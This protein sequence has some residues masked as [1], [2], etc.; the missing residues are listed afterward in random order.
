MTAPQAS[1]FRP[2]ER[3]RVS[4]RAHAG[5]HRT[6]RYIQGKVGQVQVDN[7]LW[8]NPETRAYGGSGLPE[9]RVYRVCFPQAEL[10]ESYE[11]PSHDSLIVDIFEHW[12]ENVQEED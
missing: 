8:I 4:A 6:P 11:G 2:G 9:I 12:L 7:G 10:W 3:V 5:H 1:R